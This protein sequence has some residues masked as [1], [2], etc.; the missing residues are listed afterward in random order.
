[1]TDPAQPVI[2]IIKSGVKFPPHAYDPTTTPDTVTTTT[3]RRN[4]QIHLSRRVMKPTMVLQPAIYSV[5]STL[6]LDP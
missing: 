3:R 2:T 1:M 4:G 5:T 6:K